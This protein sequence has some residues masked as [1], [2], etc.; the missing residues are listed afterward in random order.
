MPA[1]RHRA[2]LILALV[3]IALTLLLHLPSWAQ[4]PSPVPAQPA[5]QPLIIPNLSNPLVSDWIWLDGRRLFKVAATKGN[6]AERTLAVQ[7][8]LE[9]IKHSYL[10]SETVEPQVEIR[11][12]NNLPVI[13]V[14]DQH[15]LT[16]TTLDAELRG[17]EITTLDDDIKSIVERALIHSRTEREP[18]FLQQQGMIA[19][20]VI[21]L[22]ILLN[23]LVHLWLPRKR[24]EQNNFHPLNIG[25]VLLG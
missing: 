10:R 17:M 7:E 3:S 18:Q 12:S 2:R 21:G 11:T 4:A 24:M 20:G 15:L 25:S 8:S 23:R 13:Y 1:I 19:G 16:I 22:A 9:T 14:D 6:L 5:Q